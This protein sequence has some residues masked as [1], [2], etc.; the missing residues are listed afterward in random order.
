VPLPANEV[1]Q[2]RE[3]AGVRPLVVLPHVFLR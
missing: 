2:G 3:D 1:H